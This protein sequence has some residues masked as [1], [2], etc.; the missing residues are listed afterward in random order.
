ME[1]LSQNG[2]PMAALIGKKIIDFSLK[3]FISSSFW[4]ERVALLVQLHL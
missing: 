1:K 2:I 3:S 4:T